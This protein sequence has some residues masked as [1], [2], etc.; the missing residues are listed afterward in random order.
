MEPTVERLEELK[1]WLSDFTGHFA[2]VRYEVGTHRIHG[3]VGTMT[4]VADSIDEAFLN[5][6]YAIIARGWNARGI[7]K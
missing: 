4:L 3:T 1:T 6:P 2:Y 7:D 5:W